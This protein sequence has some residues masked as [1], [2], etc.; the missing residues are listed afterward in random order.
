M[1][2][3][4]VTSKC[5]K[6]ETTVCL[7]SQYHV[8]PYKFENIFAV[9]VLK[10]NF[11]YIFHFNFMVK[12]RLTFN[13]DVWQIYLHTEPSLCL[14]AKPSQPSEHI[15]LLFKINVMA[16]STFDPETQH[17][18]LFTHLWSIY[19]FAMVGRLNAWEIKLVQSLSV[20]KRYHKYVKEVKQK[21]PR[22][23]KASLPLWCI[24]VQEKPKW[25]PSE[26][27]ECRVGWT[28]CSTSRMKRQQAH[29]QLPGPC[30][31]HLR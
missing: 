2:C 8:E 12:F 10:I 3:R 7:E 5:R 9:L 26:E 22:H 20:Q 24:W 27:R 31:P 29:W 30:T 23:I 19:C 14:L 6:S 17:L 4:V 21:E 18:E 28:D 16:K 15:Y 1:F 13:I 11:E 25:K